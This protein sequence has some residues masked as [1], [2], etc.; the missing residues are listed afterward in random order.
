VTRFLANENMPR[1]SIHLL[2]SHDLDITWIREIA[3]G[4]DDRIVLD[5]ARHSNRVILTF[6]HDY[7]DLVFRQRLRAPGIVLYRMPRLPDPEEPARIILKLTAQSN[8]TF[9]GSFIVVSEHAI[10]IVPMPTYDSRGN[11]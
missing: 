11:G 10:R 8:V 9:L 5:L 6:D 2:R 3:S 4:V 7:G 1:A